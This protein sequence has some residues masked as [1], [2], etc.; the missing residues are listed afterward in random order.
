M[1][2]MGA[3]EMVA[4]PSQKGSIMDI[5]GV[6]M[7]STTPGIIIFTIKH[8]NSLKTMNSTSSNTGSVCHYKFVPFIVS[9]ALLMAATTT[10]SSITVTTS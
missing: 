5:I 7:G 3:W 8:S 4:G 10:T 1:E 6:G 9:M 2:W